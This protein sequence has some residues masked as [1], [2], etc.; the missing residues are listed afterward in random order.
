MDL[1]QGYHSE[2]LNA[3]DTNESDARFLSLHDW[4]VIGK[5]LHGSYDA[6]WV[7]GYSY[8][9]M[10]LAMAA[11]A[12]RSLPVLLREEQTLLH[13]R[14]WPKRWI[15]GVFL[16]L[17]CRWVYGLSIGS[18]NREWFRHYGTPEHRIFRV[19]YCVDNELLQRQA[20]ELESRKNELRAEFG[21]GDETG[22]VILFV[23]KFEPKKQPLLALDAFARVRQRHQCVLLLVGEGALGPAL[24]RRIEQAGIPDVHFA[25]F[26]NRSRIARAYAAADLFILPSSL[27]E[28]F[29]L[30]VAEAM[31]FS[32]PVVL[33][34]KVG[35]AAD[36]VRD[37]ENG[38]V[39][40]SGDVG[41]LAEAL[42]LL[43]VDGQRRCLAGKRSR[44]VI[45]EWHYGMAV[46]GIVQACQ[47]AVRGRSGRP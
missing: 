21:I 26:L 42:E 32:L 16:R 5:V 3:A 7:H 19:P 46:E 38:F 25:G 11:A 43:V 24:H 15:R 28:T 44:Q 12:V 18:N 47:A 30:V 1:L 10:W 8:L 9:T 39:V 36:L 22:P 40:P 17:L 37:G 13:G 31:N 45:D 6:L 27:H 34:D 35:C 2:F 14:P 20:S 4:D 29:G 23:G 33:S 41:S